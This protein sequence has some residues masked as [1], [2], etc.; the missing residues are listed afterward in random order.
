MEELERNNTA[1]QKMNESHEAQL[2][3][4]ATAMQDLEDKLESVQREYQRV[5]ERSES[6]ELNQLQAFRMS[7]GKKTPR[8]K[9]TSFS[10]ELAQDSSEQVTAPEREQELLKTVE[11]LTEKFRVTSYQ[12]QKYEKGLR[13]VLLENQSLARSL[14]RA[15]TDVSELQGRLRGYEEAMEK[16][17]LERS[18]GSPMPHT[19]S[20]SSTP[21]LGN[22]FHYSS[23]TSPSE[24]SHKSVRGNDSTLGT[25][26]FSE[27]DSQ[28]SDLQ[29][30][31]DQLVQQCTCSAGL[32]HRNRLKLTNMS[33]Y[34]DGLSPVTTQPKVN[35]SGA[36]TP[37]KDLFDEVFSTLQQT[38]AVADKL[39]ERNKSRN[40]V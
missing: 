21:T 38:A 19:L 32:A 20:V 4:K 1:L 12:K 25:S 28:Y 30:H 26:L 15:E 9:S 18:Y 39:I 40:H 33:D 23:I 22:V 29:E 35:S 5:K 7:G 2:E 37:F 10:G 3:Q 11:E 36:G 14:E 6:L 27:L 16:Q 34:A 31:Y 17:S 8:K 13:E 24:D